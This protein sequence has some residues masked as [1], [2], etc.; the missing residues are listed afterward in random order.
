MNRLYVEGA[1]FGFFSFFAKATRLL[2]PLVVVAVS[3]ESPRFAT[4]DLQAHMSG[5]SAIAA[6]VFKPMHFPW[7][8]D[9]QK[10]QRISVLPKR[11]NVREI[12][13]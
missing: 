8:R 2:V 12:G 9:G 5:S 13:P 1:R 11:G 10:S 4:H 6:F 7:K 3:V